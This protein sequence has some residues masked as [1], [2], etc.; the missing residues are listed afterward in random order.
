MDPIVKWTVDPIVQ[1]C[2][3]SVV[4]DPFIESS[5]A[6]VAVSFIAPDD[7]EFAREWIVRGSWDGAMDVVCFVVCLS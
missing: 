7:I 1:A 5:A 6:A 2:P 3:R 4:V